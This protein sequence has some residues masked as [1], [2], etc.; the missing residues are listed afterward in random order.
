[1]TDRSTA[2]R[3]RAARAQG[4]T[5]ASGGDVDVRRDL[6]RQLKALAVAVHLDEDVAARGLD[7]RRGAGHD[8][9]LQQLLEQLGLELHGLA[10]PTDHDLHRP[11]DPARALHD[12]DDA[13]E[14]RTRRLAAELVE[15]RDRV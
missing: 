14:E 8:T 3:L 12:V 15:R 9:R 2:A 4:L 13:V 1:W 5:A 7:R 11:L 10:E 6:G